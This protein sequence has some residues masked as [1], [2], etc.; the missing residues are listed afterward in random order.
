M[1]TTVQKVSVLQ[2]HLVNGGA[3]SDVGDQAGPGWLDD[4]DTHVVGQVL[5]QVQSRG[6]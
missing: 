3:L 6:I 4:L 5:D 2:Q 1:E